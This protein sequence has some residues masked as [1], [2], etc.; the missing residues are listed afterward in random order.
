MFLRMIC[1]ISLGLVF[2]V[3][4]GSSLYAQS[5]TSADS[6]LQQEIEYPNDK[7]LSG[8]WSFSLLG[9][10][11][12]DAT[13]SETYAGAKLNLLGALNLI[14]YAKLK[15]DFSLVATN[16]FSQAR[17]GKDS[18]GNGININEAILVVNEDGLFQVDAGIINQKFLN[19]PLL[20]SNLPFPG[21]RE[22]IKYDGDY[23]ALGFRA[24]QAI[25]TSRTLDSQKRSEKEQTPTFFTESVFAEFQ[26]SNSTEAQASYTRYRFK[27][28]PTTVA[29]NGRLL[30]NSVPFST[31]AQSQ[32]LYQFEGALYQVNISQELPFESLL[33]LNTQLLQNAKAPTA[34]NRGYLIEA[35]L[36]F[37]ILSQKMGLYVSNF[38]NESD[39][40][41]GQY[42]SS[43]VGH[44]NMKGN[45]FG[46]N[47]I[48]NNLFMVSAQY[49]SSDVISTNL[50][51]SKRQ[52]LSLSLETLYAEF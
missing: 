42:N 6:N 1:L 20:V 34:F 13:D 22:T 51:N 50:V 23:L 38:F 33:T 26:L 36:S 31:A 15:A 52:N 21:I 5:L 12:E 29:N 47:V 11:L 45:S 14:D 4:L 43:R 39:S 7:R 24:Q 17:F 19:A 37:P 2:Q 49:T 41:P 44:N 25:P 27:N 9:Q 18:L 10:T 40:S 16:G 48:I 28:L 32:F 46:I 3:Q 30:G 35:G 8:G